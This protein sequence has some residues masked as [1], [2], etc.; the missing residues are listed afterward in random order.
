MMTSTR[1]KGIRIEA[2][3][4]SRDDD[5]PQP[6]EHTIEKNQ[7]TRSD[8]GPCHR[9][10]VAERDKQAQAIERAGLVKS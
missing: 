6:T 1:Q 8:D 7:S 9:K 10:P 4:K 5:C 2:C 3:K